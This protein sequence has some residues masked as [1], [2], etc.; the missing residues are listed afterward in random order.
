MAKARPKFFRRGAFVG[1]YKPKA[2]ELAEERFKTLARFELGRSEYRTPI[3]KGVA[4]ALKCVF[5][6]PIPASGTKKFKLACLN[7]LV[8][9]VKK[10]DADNLVKFILDCCNGLVWHDDCQVTK[11]EAVKVYGGE[12]ATIIEIEAL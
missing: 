4:L 3:D 8:P 7:G 5:V 1:A 11:I 6:M 9:H 12:P 10:P 2:Q